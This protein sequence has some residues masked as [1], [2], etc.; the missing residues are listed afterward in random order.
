MRQVVRY[1]NRPHCSG[2]AFQDF[3]R[4]R[5]FQHVPSSLLYPRTSGFIESQVT[6]V[7][8]AYLRA[9][10][11]RRDPHMALLYLITTTT[12]P[13]LPS[14]AELLLGRVI[15]N[16]LP[17]TTPGVVTSRLTERP[18]WLVRKATSWTKTETKSNHPGSKDTEMETS[19]STREKSIQESPDNMVWN[20]HWKRAERHYIEPLYGWPLGR[21]IEVEP[22]IDGQ[23]VV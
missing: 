22:G 1:D 9:K 18:L 23:T 15:Q 5:G 7:K 2:K 6:S 11:T 13:K 16:N 8:A 4:E 21:N 19:R 14:P 17:R 3:A 10:N 12:G 20:P